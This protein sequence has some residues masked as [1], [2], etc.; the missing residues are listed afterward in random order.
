MAHR[1]PLPDPLAI[2]VE[3]GAFAVRAEAA[4]RAVAREAALALG[5][6]SFASLLAP[7][8]RSERRLQERLAPLAHANRVLADPRRREL[9]DTLVQELAARSAREASDPRLLEAVEGILAREALAPAPR[10]VAEAWRRVLEAAGAGEDRRTRARLAAIEAERARL[11][12]EYEYAVSDAEDAFTV[13]LREEALPD[14]A[15]EERQPLAA[16][17]RAAGRDGLRVGLRAAE[18]GLVLA[19]S[20]DR[21]LREAIYRARATVASA[22]G[23]GGRDFDNAERLARILA[24]RQERARLLSRKSPAHD[25]FQ[26]RMARDPES[27]LA[28]LCALGELVRPRAEA[29]LATLSAFAERQLGL[30]A[31]EAWDLAWVRD[32]HG[33]AAFGIARERLRPCFP[34]AAVL[35]GLSRFLARHFGLRLERLS[36]PAYPGAF[37][38]LIRNADGGTL[39]ALL[40]DL[41]ARPGKQDGAWMD[42]WRA[43]GGGE[44]PLAFLVADALPAGPDGDPSLAPEE[45]LTLFHEMGHVLH[46]L[47]DRSGWP[48]LAGP[49]G[50]PFDGMELP[51]MLLERLGRAPEVLSDCSRD[52]ASGEPL[53]RDVS[54]RLAAALGFGEGIDLLRQI[55]LARFDLELHLDPAAAEPDRPLAV[56]ERVR[57]ETALLPVPAFDRLPLHFGHLFGGGYEAGYYGYLWAEGLARQVEHALARPGAGR[58]FLDEV[59]A[60]GEIEPLAE[61]IG[62]FLGEPPDPL[63]GF[64]RSGRSD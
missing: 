63:A 7:I 34:L 33:R 27:A 35:S 29:E 47:A 15:E 51:S 30:S 14:L 53:S 31:L 6:P 36:E 18:A 26:H 19:R 50:A 16:A 9:Y 54:A 12:L 11:E 56:L 49:D 64:A 24:L 43:P 39:G 2:P 20:P 41:E 4:R 59:L 61:R 3:E 44:L 32:R 46:A 10:A 58:R 57:R 55:E 22:L 48:S 1:S 5:A 8:E 40:C 62:R 60:P 25:A 17:A 52:P 21:D 42:L 38:C 13:D 45:V 37:W 23:P 28:F